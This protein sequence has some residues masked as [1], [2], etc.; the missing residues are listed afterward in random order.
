MLLH[1]TTLLCH[2]LLHMILC[3]SLTHTHSHTPSH[4]LTLSY[5]PLILPH[6]LTLPS[7]LSHPHTLLHS[8]TLSLSQVPKAEVLVN[9]SCLVD[10]AEAHFQ[11]IGRMQAYMEKCQCSISSKS[12]LHTLYCI[13]LSIL[14]NTIPPYSILFCS[15]LLLYFILIKS[16]L[17]FC[18]VL[19]ASLTFSSLVLFSSKYYL[20]ELH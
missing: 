3:H 9:L 4:S 18:L 7:S 13:L 11:D 16:F 15:M 19:F 14:F 5:I 10:F 1:Y 6:S 12:S 20:H 8:L 17:F 2:T